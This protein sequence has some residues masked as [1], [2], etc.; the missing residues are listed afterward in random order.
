MGRTCGKP[1]LAAGVRV[2]VETQLAASGRR[3]RG[4]GACAVRACS[5]EHECEQQECGP[6]LHHGVVAGL[7]SRAPRMAT[8]GGKPLAWRQS[9]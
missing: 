5:R 8:V 2:V 1:G 3:L 4:D 9:S 7:G 6:G